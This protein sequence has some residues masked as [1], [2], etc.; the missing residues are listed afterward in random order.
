MRNGAKSGHSDSRLMSWYLSD[1]SEIVVGIT[2]KQM[3]IVCVIYGVDTM[4]CECLQ[5]KTRA[6]VCQHSHSQVHQCQ[7]IV[8]RNVDAFT[9]RIRRSGVEFA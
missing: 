1:R 9:R 4:E 6:L 5:D 7:S 3:D 2:M 8:V